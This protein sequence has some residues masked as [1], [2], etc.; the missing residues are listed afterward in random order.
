MKFI[1]RKL[2]VYFR[3]RADMNNRSSRVKLGA[4]E[5]NAADICDHT[6]RHGKR[7]GGGDRD[8]PYG[9]DPECGFRRTVGLVW[10]QLFLRDLPCIFE[11][12]HCESGAG[13]E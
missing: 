7:R 2:S 12:A 10:W 3:A 13:N 11:S 8:Q 9:S 1:C 4:W 5:Q 6:R